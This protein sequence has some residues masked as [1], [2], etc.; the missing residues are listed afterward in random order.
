MRNFSLAVVLLVIGA[1]TSFE[2]RYGMTQEQWKAA[3]ARQDPS[4]QSCIRE[5]S[6]RLGMT[7]EQVVLVLARPINVNR[8]VGA[9]GAHE[10]WV[11]YRTGGTLYLY[12]EGG[13]LK[14]WQE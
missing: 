9:F 7:Q 2:G 12:F 3:F 14:S 6:I 4:M 10:Q 13:I 1:C 11:Y 5:R 8:T